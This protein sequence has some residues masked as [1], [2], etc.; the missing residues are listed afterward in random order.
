MAADV[1]MCAVLVNNIVRY[2][3]RSRTRAKSQYKYN[4]CSLIKEISKGKDKGKSKKVLRLKHMQIKPGVMEVGLSGA[5]CLINMIPFITHGL[6]YECHINGE[7][8]D[9]CLKLKKLGYKILVD[10]APDLEVLHLME[11]KQLKNQDLIDHYLQGGFP[12]YEK[13]L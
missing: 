3:S 1:G 6:Q 8:A 10:T 4:V 13:Y 11:I 7:D 2:L 9:I 12:D 5:C